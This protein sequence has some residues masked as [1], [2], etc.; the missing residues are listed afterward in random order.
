VL[1][2][3]VGI[4]LGRA[5]LFAASSGGLRVDD[6]AADLAILAAL[7]SAATGVPAPPAT[8]FLGE[9]SLTGLVRPAAGLARRLAAAEAAGCHLVVA[10]E[11]E[12]SV[13]DA[14]IVPVRHVGE[15][16]AWAA[17]AA[18]S[19]AARARREAS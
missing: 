12:G 10:R 14:R 11:P 1:D 3:A 17:P 8:A 7:A 2:R 4:P 16:L 6:P 13:P 15:A 19:G 18:A 5:E 9:V